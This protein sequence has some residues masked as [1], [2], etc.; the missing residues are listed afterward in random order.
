MSHFNL[1]FTVW[2][3]SQD[4]DHKPQFLKRKESRSGS[5]RGPSANQTSALPLGRTDFRGCT[6]GG[7]AV[8]C[9]HQFLLARQVELP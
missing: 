2:A 9:L 8:P 6:F 4:I 7:V 5:N 1:S 3:K